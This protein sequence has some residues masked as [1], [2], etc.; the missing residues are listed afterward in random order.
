MLGKQT[1]DVLVMGGAVFALFFG[2]GNLIFPP[3]LGASLGSDWLMGALGF[4]L[5]TVL[6]SFF[7]MLAVAKS[8]SGLSDLSRNIHKPVQ[9]GVGVVLMLAIGPLLAIPRT[10]ATTLEM[11][12]E[13]LFA[14]IVNVNSWVVT[15]LYFLGVLFFSISPTGILDKIGK[16]LT[17]ALVLTLGVII[18]KS[19]TNPLGEAVPL[20]FSQPFSFSFV[21]GY[22]TLDPLGGIVF[23]IATLNALAEK[24]YTSK[25]QKIRMIAK[26]AAIAGLG[27]I[28]IYT[29]LVYL[30]A[31]G[32]LAVAGNLSRTAYFVAL[33]EQLLGT[34]GKYILGIAVTVACFTTA[35][36]LS[37]AAAVYFERITKG[38][39][40]YKATVVLVSVISFLLANLGVEQIV[41]FSAPLLV[42]IYPAVTVL[43]FLNLGGR[44]LNY[45]FSHRVPFYT[46]LLFG[47]LS[48]LPTVGLEIKW[49][50]Q[51]LAYIPLSSYG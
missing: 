41:R 27:L 20:G 17:P 1:K 34:T 9:L 12:I 46:A 21:E 6:L 35:V 14:G 4:C 43:I 3:A 42:L 40:P 10:G 26:S 33:I 15:G 48:V 24:G 44:R 5:T 31:S 50:S 23:T 11:G 47:F 13:P 28:F 51:L 45:T 38:R 36:G 37:V 30:G 25:P 18:V 49:L 39:L 29:G 2:A 32:K 7:S 22:Q 16:L 19:I 8:G